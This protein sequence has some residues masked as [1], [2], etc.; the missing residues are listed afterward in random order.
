M[1]GCIALSC[2]AKNVNA[3]NC[4]VETWEPGSVCVKEGDVILETH[5][6]AARFLKESSGRVFT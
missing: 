2:I 1:R 4:L 6:L 5:S 3:N